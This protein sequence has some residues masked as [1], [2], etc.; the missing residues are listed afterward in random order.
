M[1]HEIKDKKGNQIREGDLIKIYHFTAAYRRKKHYMFKLVYIFEGYL[2][3]A[4]LDGRLPEFGM[5]GFDAR[6]LKLYDFEI[7]STRIDQ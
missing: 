2:R 4:H 7:I 1:I 5:H 6:G 3:C